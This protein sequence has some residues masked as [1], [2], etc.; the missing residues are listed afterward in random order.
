MDIISE[1]ILL[2]E[3]LSLSSDQIGDNPNMPKLLEEI[4]I[5]LEK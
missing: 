4:C 2:C 3:Q 5:N 1:L